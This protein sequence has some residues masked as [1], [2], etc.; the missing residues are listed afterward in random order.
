MPEFHDSP[1]R[2]SQLTRDIPRKLHSAENVSI[3]ETTHN[4]ECT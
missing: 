3:L 1:Q 2:R 4:L